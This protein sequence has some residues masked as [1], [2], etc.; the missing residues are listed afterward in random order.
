MT[1]GLV[2]VSDR[3]L[4]RVIDALPAASG[5]TLTSTTGAT[6]EAMGRRARSV[7]VIV[8]HDGGDADD[9]ELARV[10]KVLSRAAPQ[11]G[12]LRALYVHGPGARALCESNDLFV[13]L[14][15]R[16][17]ELA[18]ALSEDFEA[19]GQAAAAP[20]AALAVDV[21]ARLQEEVERLRQQSA[22]GLEEARREI[23]SLRSQ[24]ATP[25]DAIDD[26]WARAE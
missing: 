8:A 16:Q 23:R 5:V 2:A 24:Q 26:G 15:E 13:P 12:V 11:R 9:A 10:L 6:L 20:A 7:V 14:P 21:L 22:H 25:L 4:D 3:L 19:T 1:Q 17:D 18:R